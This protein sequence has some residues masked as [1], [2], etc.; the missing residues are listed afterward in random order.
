MSKPHPSASL[1]VGD[2]SQDVTEGNLFEIFNQVGPVASIRVCRDAVTRRSLGYAYVNFHSVVDAERALD[3]LNN[4]QIKGRPCR[5]MWSQ[6]D[7]SIRKSG[8]GNIFIKNLDPEIGHKEL[9][10]TFSAFGNILSCKVA[11]GDSNQS[12]GYGFVHFENEES[13]LKAIAKVNGMI[14]GSKKVFVGKFI[15]KKERLKNKESS[16]TNVYVKN[17]DKDSM[18]DSE[19]EIMFKKYGDITSARVMLKEDEGESKGFGFVNFAKHE[20]AVTAVEDINRG[21]FKN[22]EGVSLYAGR[23]QKK[24]EREAELKKKFEQLKIERMTKYQ[25]IN[26]Y[27]KNLEDD[28]SEE[29]MKKEFAPFGSVK[30]VK[31]MA[32]DKGN[33]KGFGF[34]CFSTPE[35]A[36]RAIT[37]MNGRILSGCAKPLYV[38]MHEPKE[39][40]RQKLAAQHAA[41]QKGIRANSLPPHQGT[42]SMYGPGG[43][44]VFYPPSGNIPQGFVGYPPQQMI[45]RS[46]WGGT[47]AP[48]PQPQ[49]QVQPIPP[50]YVMP[51]IQ[52]HGPRGRGGVPQGNRRVGRRDQ[53]QTR[54]NQEPIAMPHALSPDQPLTVAQL[55][56]IQPEQQKL[57]IG[58]KLYPLVHKKQPQLAGKITG[59]LLDG[60][61][62]DELLQLLE[63]E[64]NLAAKIEEAVSVL[65]GAKHKQ[66]NDGDPGDENEAEK[67]NR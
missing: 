54:P 36:Q 47:A 25:G 41:R 60:G 56:T 49:Y 8:V 18:S 35:E 11:M 15:P 22:K 44:P 39:V 19:L 67:P 63:N 51:P 34:V 21:E 10:D 46:R 30:S 16:W 5:I 12:K 13:A 66:E 14:M 57:V 28:V 42:P 65:E 33:S 17:L 23:A 2:L 40:R 32:D 52:R 27:I 6:R 31:I 1:Y 48:P 20:D 24:A 26:L 53:P 3:T 64:E 7:P 59:M 45:P 37:E 61:Y 4:T 55:N 9:H 43:A 62:M 58:E 29:R 38:N 50:N